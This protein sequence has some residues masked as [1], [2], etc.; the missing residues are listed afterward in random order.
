MQ[1]IKSVNPATGE[2]IKKYPTSSKQEV[3]KAVLKAREVFGSW[4]ETPIPERIKHLSCIRKTLIKDQDHIVELISQQTGKTYVESLMSDILPTLE[5]ISYYEENAIKILKPENRP[6]PM[7]Y[8]NNSSSILYSPLGVV[9]IISPWNF[10]LQLSLAPAITAL[11]AGNTIVLKPSELSP[12]VGEIIEHICVGASEELIQVIQGPG[13]VGQYLIKSEPDMVFFTGG[14]ETGKKIMQS[15][16]EKLIPVELEMGGKDPMI[17]YEDADLSRAAK[18]AVYGAFANAGQM[19]VSIERLYVQQEVLDELTELIVEQT[20]KLRVGVG[21]DA[22]IGPIINPKQMRVIDEQVS[23]AI[24]KGARNLTE[25]KTEGRF[26]QP[27]ILVD[28]NHSMKVMREETFGPVLPIQSF[29]DMDEAVKL[30]N[31]S[32]YG[33]NASVFTKDTKKAL[34]TANK[35]QTGN[36]YIN[37]VVKNI[38]NP[39]LPFGGAKKSGIGMYHGPEGLRRFSQQTSVMVNK[40]K[41]IEPNWFPYSRKKYE[42]IQKLL[43]T[44][45]GNLNPG[46]KLGNLVSLYKEIR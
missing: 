19:C 28:V 39:H 38:G 24:G 32:I 45:Y 11:A 20:N 22:D 27:L 18:A 12:V 42:M 21:V 40:N 16:A 31:D 9:G 26:M 34:N 43:K 30:A 3:K 14:V 15:C 5:L 10:P 17:V 46:E 1:Y 44:N 4:S 2:C 13:Q 23:D 41:G 7:F 29:R 6:T 36:C 25:Y 33:L 37:D 35:L 8:W